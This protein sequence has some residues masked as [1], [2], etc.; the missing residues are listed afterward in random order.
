[1]E[2]ESD[3]YTNR[4]WCFRYSNLRTIKGT[5]GLGSWR[6]SGD[7]PNY[8]MVENGQITEKSPG[9]LRRFAVTQTALTDHQLK[10]M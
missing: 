3:D 2:H 7:Y 1:M 9:D 5:E 4:D 10:L 8:S 6:T